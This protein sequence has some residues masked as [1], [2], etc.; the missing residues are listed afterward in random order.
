M[1]DEQKWKP[2]FTFIRPESRLSFHLI[3]GLSPPLPFTSLTCTFLFILPASNFSIRPNYLTT[4]FFT[5][6]AS[7]FS[8]PYFILTSSYLNLPFFLTA[9]PPPQ[10]AL[11]QCKHVSIIYIKEG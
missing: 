11:S 1:M 6:T 3:L 9:H 2:S 10:F 7:P 5:F 8:I 4:S